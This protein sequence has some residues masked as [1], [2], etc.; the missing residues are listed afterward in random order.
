MF[1]KNVP[2]PLSRGDVVKAL[3]S[4]SGYV[5]LTLSEPNKSQNYTRIGWVSFDEEEY[6]NRCVN[7]ESINIKGHLL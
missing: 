5:S 7:E 6:C 3:S 2:L 1:I 4:L